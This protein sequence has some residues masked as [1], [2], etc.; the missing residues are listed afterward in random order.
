MDIIVRQFQAADEW[1]DQEI[2]ESRHQQ[3][4][5]AGRRCT[6]PDAD[7]AAAPSRPKKSFP[8]VFPWE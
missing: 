1:T 2:T 6:G 3:H 5:N 8:A 7:L 4:K